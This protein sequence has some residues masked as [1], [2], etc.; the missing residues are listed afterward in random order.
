MSFNA[1]LGNSGN[2]KVTFDGPTQS[3]TLKNQVSSGSR[4]DSLADVDTSVSEANGS[5]LVYNNSTDTYVQRDVLSF[6]V[7]SGAFKLDGGSD[8]F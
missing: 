5:I 6:D 8:G 1:K 7:D 4:I 3:I 2:F